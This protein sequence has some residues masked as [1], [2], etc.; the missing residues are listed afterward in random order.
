MASHDPQSVSL[1]G[2]I[3]TLNRLQKDGVIGEWAIFGSVAYSLWTE[4][5]TTGDV[6]ILIP[7][8]NDVEYARQESAV[9]RVGSGFAP[10]GFGVE[11]HGARV[12][13]LPTTMSQ[14]YADALHD[15]AQHTIRGEPVRLVTPPYLIMMASSPGAATRRVACMMS[16]EQKGSSC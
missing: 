13:L 11:L 2:V 9:A 7:V 1:L 6:D 4:P 15:A 16:K 12:E 3:G 10:G 8:E 14:L 5:I